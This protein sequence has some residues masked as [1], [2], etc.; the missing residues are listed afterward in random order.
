MGAPASELSE[1][2]TNF[3]PDKPILEYLGQNV[4]ASYD[5]VSCLILWI[6]KD[7]QS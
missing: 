7:H 1:A 5:T 4:S 3:L 2:E 6:V